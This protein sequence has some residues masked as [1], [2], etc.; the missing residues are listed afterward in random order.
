MLHHTREDTGDEFIT[1]V[2]ELN[3]YCSNVAHLFNMTKRV[4]AVKIV[5]THNLKLHLWN[6]NL[7]LF[8][9]I[10]FKK[11]KTNNFI[12]SKRSHLRIRKKFQKFSQMML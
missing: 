9:N 11:C 3:K 12:V 6:K 4:E 10:F 7:K 8:C 1:L 5:C 2:L